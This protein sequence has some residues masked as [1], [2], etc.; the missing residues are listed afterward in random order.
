MQFIPK[1]DGVWQC[2]DCY[3]AES[4][5]LFTDKKAVVIEFE[6]IE[7]SWNGIETR[8]FTIKKLGLRH[9]YLGGKLGLFSVSPHEMIT[10]DLELFT[11]LAEEMN[12]EFLGS[13]SSFVSH[14]FEHFLRTISFQATNRYTLFGLI[15]GFLVDNESMLFRTR[16]HQLKDHYALLDKISALDF[17]KKLI[18]YRKLLVE[19]IRAQE[20]MLKEIED[21]AMRTNHLPIEFKNWIRS[22]TAVYGDH[23]K[24]PF[25]DRARAWSHFLKQCHVIPIIAGNPNNPQAVETAW[26]F[27]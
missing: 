11:A 21:V 20:G 1:A 5:S 12:A 14:Q 9:L 18:A 10:Y 8:D 19:N 15:K 27:S 4:F 22:C 26:L 13:V 3:I 17:E 16:I 6:P 23:F 2:G 25:A 7:K 24:T